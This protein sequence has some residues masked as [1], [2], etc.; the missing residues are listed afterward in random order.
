MIRRTIPAVA[1][2]VLVVAGQAMAAGAA[3]IVAKMPTGSVEEGR[4]LATELIKLG[5]PALAEVCKGI[6]PP[7][8]TNDSKPR[9]AIHAVALE[10]TR[11]GAEA[12]RKMVAGALIAALESAKDREVKAFFIRHL[13]LVGKDEAVPPLAKL[14]A[15][16]SLHEPATQAL[17]RIRTPN[18]I[19]ALLQALPG[20]KD[21]QRLTLVRALGRLGVKDA[22]PEMLKDTGSADLTLRLAALRGLAEM[23][24]PKA[25]PAL[26][27]AAAS[28]KPYE[29]AEATDL[30][31]VYAAERAKAGK[32]GE[33]AGI[34]RD[35]IK[36]RTEARERNIVCSALETLM[37]ALG[38]D[39][40]PD[41]NAALNHGDVWVRTAALE[42]AQN[43]S[44]VT[45]HLVV[46]A[47]KGTPELRVE[48]IAMLGRRG[49][50]A[51][52][53]FVVKFM[54]EEDPAIQAASVAAAEMLGGKQAMPAILEALASED[55]GVLVAVTRAIGRQ[56]DAKVLSDAVAALPKASVP[57]RCAVLQLL[58]GLKAKAH[59]GSVLAIAMDAPNEAVQNAALR[60][61]VV[62]GDEK[63]LPRLVEVLMDAT[64]SGT[65]GEAQKA[66]IAIGRRIDDP[67]KRSAPVIA[68]M[69]LA[70]GDKRTLLVQTLPKVGGPNALEAAVKETKSAD[71]AAKDAGIRALAAW[72]DAR[73]APA[74]LAIAKGSKELKHH[75]LAMR[76]YVAV[77]D[78]DTTL[79]GKK[80]A[81]LKDGMA[82]AKRPDEKKLVLGALGNVRSVASLQLVAAHLDDAALAEE[83]AAAAV[84]IACPR[85]RRDKGLRNPEVAPVLRKVV[86]V[87]K[88]AGIRK[89]AADHLKGLPK[90]AKGEKGDDGPEAEEGFVLLFNGKDLTGWTGAVKGYVPQPDGSL[91]C[92]K[93]GNL[94][95][96]KEYGDF[97]LRFEFKLTAGANNGLGIR[98]PNKGNAAYVG[99]ELQILDNSAPRYAKL[100]PY[101][102]H[103]S[104]YGVVPAKRGHQKPVGEWNVQEVTAKGRRITVVLNGV[105]IV[106]ADL[107]EVTKDGKH[108][109]RHPGLLREKG[110]IGFLGHGSKLWFRN[111]RIKEL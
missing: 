3:D 108:V 47:S 93:G 103:G 72:P 8:P 12:D 89:K 6:V 99:M 14:L 41:L 25:L 56:A 42:V 1:L 105:T 24:E 90:G 29:R 91:C 13:Q 21:G 61:L 54:K 85:D 92:L 77:V 81:M 31:I 39:A 86:E 101:Q 88:N 43:M 70:K 22:A 33:C 34:C 102:Y 82:A 106:D 28:D 96:A 45:P 64:S 32:P 79:G 44:A 7:G 62:L 65:R 59:A 69:V 100:Q 109:K 55:P 17:I 30:L 60:A 19:A 58:G 18:V 71:A 40:L 76:G 87:S 67:A 20:A 37:G 48:R 10:S 2:A 27:R 75:V 107:D 50:K 23:G 66:I 83:A 26:K 49:D 36:T 16:P 5:P 63:A 110:Y 73:A 9:F 84:K 68:A 35:L 95:T 11:P 51:A 111:I 94:Y 74:L 78:K 4:K 98:T 15:D 80:L 104:I 97:V 38:R 57:G 46:L 52:L 53:P